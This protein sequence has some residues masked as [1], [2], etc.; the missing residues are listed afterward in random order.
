MLHTH[1]LIAI[2][3]KNINDIIMCVMYKGRVRTQTKKFWLAVFTNDLRQP[4]VTILVVP[5]TLTNWNVISKSKW[6]LHKY[7]L[8]CNLNSD[9]YVIS[10]PTTY[11]NSKSKNWGAVQ[12]EALFIL[13]HTTIISQLDTESKEWLIREAG[14][15]RIP[16]MVRVYQVLNPNA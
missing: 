13:Q 2:R 7:L 5:S 9:V 6:C 15:V 4:W 1:P 3:L 14:V 10:I 11:D 8:Q 16:S 12:P